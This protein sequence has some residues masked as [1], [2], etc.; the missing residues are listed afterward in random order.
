MRIA[1]IIQ[2][3]NIQNHNIKFCEEQYKKA[4]SYN[5]KNDKIYN[6]MAALYLNYEDKNTNLDIPF[7][8]ILTKLKKAIEIN[9]ES[10][11]AHRNLGLF[12][13][14]QKEFDESEKAYLKSIEL[15]S[16]YIDAYNSLAE[17]YMRNEEKKDLTKAYK[18]LQ[19]AIEIE[20]ENLQSNQLIVNYYLLQNNK[21]KS[22]NHYI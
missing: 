6:N 19:E 12:Y 11:A 5:K 18:Y 21:D 22:I 9:P 1:T 8:D 10:F 3:I 13:S 4:L 17:L 2:S 7:D 20:P 14:K 16:D 15:K